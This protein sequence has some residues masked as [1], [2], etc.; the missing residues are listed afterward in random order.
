MFVS[1]T[2]KFGR[3]GQRL[4]ALGSLLA[5]SFGCAG[6][7]GQPNTPLAQNQPTN[8]DVQS[9]KVADMEEPAVVR[10]QNPSAILAPPTPVP[11]LPVTVPQNPG[12]TVPDSTPVVPAANVTTSVPNQLQ[13]PGEP[14]II[15]VA[16][17]GTTPIYD[18]EVREAVYQNHLRE[19]LDLP[20]FERKA[21]EQQF[22]MEELHRTIEREMILSE[23]F[24]MMG[25]QKH[26]ALLKQ[27]R[28]GAAKEADQRLRDYQKRAKIETSDEFKA[29]L[30]AQG[31]TL[32]GLKRACERGFMMRVY[33]DERI[34]PKIN[35]V[36]LV[37]IKEYYNK[38][39]PEEFAVPDR[40]KW[41]DIFVRAD[42]FKTYQ[43]AKTFA[44]YLVKVAK[45][46]EDFAKLVDKFDNGNCK[47]L[48]GFGFGEER[49]K[50]SPPDLEQT[51]FNLKQG[52]VAIV[53]FEGAGF[54]VVR[55]AERTLAGKQPLDD[56][57]EGEI[58]KKLQAIIA[59]REY[60]QIVNNLW[61]RTQPQIL[62]K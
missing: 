24:A 10:S 47:A 58:R 8:A 7:P 38:I 14:Q 48:G 41:Q 59:E 30:Q 33:V 49:G 17:I 43:D 61:R 3:R 37:D 27:L 13:L 36:S 15:I 44:E 19:L 18:R 55:V 35:A 51:L 26:E 53:E 62:V 1:T 16:T 21:K 45:N 52:D 32:P 5:C 57:L 2:R 23:L 29:Y 54:H 31:L 39:N 11:Q 42:R 20:A 6:V 34:K 12:L 9:A 22:Y 50:I 4:L 56:K 46:G 28:E 40:V 60:K 25:E